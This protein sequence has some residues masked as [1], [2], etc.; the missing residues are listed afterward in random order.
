MTV[1]PIPHQHSPRRQTPTPITPHPRTQQTTLVRIRLTQLQPR[2][3]H[4][5]PLPVS[6]RHQLH[7]R[8]LPT[9]RCPP[10]VLGEKCPCIPHPCAVHKGTRRVGGRWFGGDALLGKPTEQLMQAF[11]GEVMEAVDER[12]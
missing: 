2:H 4:T 5:T 9:H 8:P 1:Q 10:Q 7:M 6:Q 12:A 11:V 3:P